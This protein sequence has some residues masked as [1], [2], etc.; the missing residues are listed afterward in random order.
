MDFNKL[1]RDIIRTA[2]EDP[3]I[4][5]NGDDQNVEY[6]RLTTTLKLEVKVSRDF[7]NA[8]GEEPRNATKLILLTFYD[9]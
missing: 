6:T 8:Q 2:K 4:M 3:S 9:Q 5:I 7:V 1:I